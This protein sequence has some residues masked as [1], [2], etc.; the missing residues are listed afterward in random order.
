[1]LKIQFFGDISLTGL[2]CIPTNHAA[3][4]QNIKDIAAQL[5]DYHLRIGNWETPI[6]GNGELNTKKKHLLTTTKEAAELI[7]PLKLNAVTLANN[8]I[9]DAGISG[10]QKTLDFLV[11]NDISYCGVGFNLE[12]AKKPFQFS[13]KGISIVLLNYIGREALNYLSLPTNSG[14]FINELQEDKT[15]D[16]IH[17]W[18]DKVDH[19]VICC[20]WGRDIHYEPPIEHRYLARKFI[21]EGAS[22]VYGGQSHIQLGYE[23]W[24]NGLIFYSLGDFIFSP[25]NHASGSFLWNQP[26]ATKK[27]GVPTVNFSKNKIELASWKYFI[28]LENSILLTEDNSDERAEKHEFFNNLISSDNEIIKKIMELKY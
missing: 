22:L 20:H 2:F 16:D 9:Y 19:V 11:K 6:F 3:V 23:N 28:Q 18:K 13:Y 27:V 1:M 24:G 14:I 4:R 12:D 7:C 26:S 10:V 15:I 5:G 25:I 8:H 21:E 17:N